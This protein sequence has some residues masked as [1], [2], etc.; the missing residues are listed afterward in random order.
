MSHATGLVRFSDGLI[1]FFEYNGTAD[2]C[3]PTLWSTRAELYEHWRNDDWKL[4]T[5]GNPPEAV[6]LHADYGRGL[7]WSST[8]CRQCQVIVDCSDPYTLGNEPGLPDW[9]KFELQ[10][11]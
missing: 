10:K 3:Q 7:N 6:E 2:V 1:R 5:C 11:L 9:V 8:A 4:C